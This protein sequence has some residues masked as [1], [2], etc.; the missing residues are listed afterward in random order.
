MAASNV[1]SSCWSN[2]YSTPVLQLADIYSIGSPGDLILPAYTSSGPKR[3]CR[4][5]GDGQRCQRPLTFHEGLRQIDGG[6]SQSSFNSH[7]SLHTS[8]HPDGAVRAS[9]PT[10]ASIRCGQDAT[11]T[12][13]PHEDL[14]SMPS[15][16]I[17]HLDTSCVSAPSPS[18]PLALVSNFLDTLA[19]LVGSPST[20]YSSQPSK[21]PDNTIMIFDSE[22]FVDT[23]LDEY[24]SFDEPQPSAATSA[25]MSPAVDF[26][27]LD[28]LCD[29]R[30]WTAESTAQL[31][32][33]TPLTGN[34]NPID[35]DMLGMGNL[36]WC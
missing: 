25:W 18:S 21:T 3:R 6:D 2:R 28:S 30:Q 23:V 29:T 24:Y 34:I 10:I 36:I 16:P 19:G 8:D 35:I 4:R 31:D 5:Q 9:G 14:S 15:A 12:I 22:I 32:G 11:A 20:P 7:L 26:D 33:S 13:S 27:W 1:D 17:L